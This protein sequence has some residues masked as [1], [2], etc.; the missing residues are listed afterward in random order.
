MLLTITARGPQA[1][2]LG[3]LLAKHPNKCQRF[4]LNH[5]AAYVFYPEAT[6]VSS[7]VALLLELDPVGLVRGRGDAPSI[8]HYV[9]DRPYVASSF[10]S[11]ALA[12]V[13][14]SA[15]A[16]RCTSDPELPKCVFEIEA[17]VSA[18]RCRGGTSLVER[19]FSPL[20]YEV[21]SAEHAL[22]TFFPDWGK[23]SIV[24]LTLTG[25]Q[26]IAD[27][28]AHLY[29][30][31]PVLDN[32]KHYFVGQDEVDKLLAKGQPW[33]AQHPERQ[34]IVDR[35]L[36]HRRHLTRDALERLTAD[37][38]L[39]VEEQAD[40]KELEE[41]ALEQSLSL[42][43]VRVSAV[44]SALRAASA[45]TVIDLGCG[46]GRLLRELMAASEFT[47]IVGMDVS[48]RALDKAEEKLRLKEAGDRQR[49]R[50]ELI[51]G[52]LLYRD[53][54]L[55]GFDAACLVEVLEH[56]E[57]D[58]LPMLERT[59]F[60]FA[61]PRVVIVTTPNAEYNVL[62]PSL[63]AGNMRH[64]DHRFEWSREQFEAWARA[65]ASRF[66]Y[67]V[68]FSPIGLADVERGAPTQ[69]AIFSRAAHESLS[70]AGAS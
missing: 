2:K 13:F 45:R 47:R 34:L 57:P 63:P 54:R 33:L 46:E 30:L 26:R 23:S 8:G 21:A 50:L 56:V 20:G 28:L 5:G 52:S 14:A 64:R 27:L 49:E 12:Q 37:Q 62:F 68:R 39:D 24:T 53:S 11:V 38:E 69:M 55:S 32:A 44:V 42:N 60:E 65:V 70:L 61:R 25:R 36:K 7:Q 1:A 43:E 22:D 18:V 58:R 9:N 31:M 19:I 16:G 59:V 17:H 51:Q 10:L 4:K 66:A 6:D 15:L 48:A 35:Y 41:Q 3:F 29:V 67:D 40:A